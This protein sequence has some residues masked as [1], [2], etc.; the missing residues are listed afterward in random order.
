LIFLE[1]EMVT[2]YETLHKGDGT[3][4]IVDK[5]TRQP[6]TFKGR[7]QVSLTED[8]A[9]EALAILERIEHEHAQQLHEG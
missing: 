1:T 8:V 6:L 7:L 4:S 2:T 9:K 5:A 3:W